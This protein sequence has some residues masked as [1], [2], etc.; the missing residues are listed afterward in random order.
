MADE[1][2]DE[3]RDLTTKMTA[4][5][6]AGDRAVSIGASMTSAVLVCVCHDM[7]DEEIRD[8]FDLA[9]G[10]AR[11]ADDARQKMGAH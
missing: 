2:V 3:I 1:T 8:L 7:T 5:A 11:A 10:E 6:L 9:L 4:L